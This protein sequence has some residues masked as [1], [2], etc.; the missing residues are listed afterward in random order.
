[1]VV[2]FFWVMA[3]EMGR[4]RTDVYRTVAF[5]KDMLDAECDFLISSGY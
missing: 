4:Q 2:L 3:L 1:M 5:M